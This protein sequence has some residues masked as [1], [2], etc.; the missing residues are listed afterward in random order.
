MYESINLWMLLTSLTPS[1]HTHIEIISL[2]SGSW[3]GT[4]LKQKQELSLYP[5]NYVRS[6]DLEALSSRL[7]MSKNGMMHF[8]P[9]R[10]CGPLTNLCLDPWRQQL[11]PWF[12]SWDA[13]NTPS[14]SHQLSFPWNS[15]WSSWV[16]AC[17][18]NSKGNRVVV[19]MYVF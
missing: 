5:D 19:G 16:P 3:N 7:I 17:A 4:Y 8:D 2:E 12:N 1:F 11:P 6:K 18:H 15:C 13:N 9:H 14:S 10:Q